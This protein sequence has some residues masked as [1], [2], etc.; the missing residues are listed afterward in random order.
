MTIVVLFLFFWIFY[1]SLIG[2]SSGSKIYTLT[3]LYKTAVSNILKTLV[4][5]TS[6][7]HREI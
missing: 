3:V 6:D 2:I 5:L 4:L 7:S 1:A